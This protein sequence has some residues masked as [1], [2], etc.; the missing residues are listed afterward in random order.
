MAS[1]SE[2]I[3][4]LDDG[5][6]FVAT[7]PS[8]FNLTLDSRAGP[9]ELV[10]GPS[11]MELQLVALGGCTGMDVISILRKMREDVED[12]SVRLTHTRAAD[13]PKV[14]TTVQIEHRLRGNALRE[15]NVRRAIALTMTRYC[16]VFAML[17][18]KVT[19][20][21][22]FEIVDAATGAVLAGEASPGDAATGAS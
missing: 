20:S 14:Y 12:Y 17:F 2:T 16:P 4:R 1:N 19:I 18:P 9:R 10:A 8:G 15:E 5:L 13:H 11:P 22:R 21:E 7:T 6:R 3:L